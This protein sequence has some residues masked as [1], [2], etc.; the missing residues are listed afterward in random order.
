M[1]NRDA[2]KRI[3]RQPSWILSQ[4]QKTVMEVG[5]CQNNNNNNKILEIV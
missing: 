5:V 3:N 4:S 1:K 2:P